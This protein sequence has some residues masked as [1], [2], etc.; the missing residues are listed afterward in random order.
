[1][2]PSAADKPRYVAA[3]FGRIAQRYD[4]M[5]SLMTL[6]QDERW[7]TAV[8]FTLNHLPSD[9]RVLDVG[10]GTGK[11]ALAVQDWHRGWRVVGV[12]FT[13]PMLAVAPREL[14]RAAADAL[15]LPFADAQFDAVVSGFLVRNLADLERG[16][17]EQLRVLRPGGTLAILETTPGPR[18]WPISTLYRL[19]FRRA[20]PFFG[21][22]I[23]GDGSAYTYLPESS[24]QFLEPSRLA[25]LLRHKGLMNVHVRRFSFGCVALTVGRKP[26]YASR[27]GEGN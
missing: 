6:G 14:P 21:R 25:D 2:L 10:S 7:R 4:L 23:A 27:P 1:V 11:L 15:V 26:R 3:M 13:L 17:S 16:L 8:A 20:V 9:S 22:L 12:D 18:L 5:N 24:L 19:Y